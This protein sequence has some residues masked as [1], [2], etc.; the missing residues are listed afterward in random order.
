MRDRILLF[1]FL[2][3][4]ISILPTAK[5]QASAPNNEFVITFKKGKLTIEP[6]LNLRRPIEIKLSL[7]IDFYKNYN[8]T[9]K[10]VYD[11]LSVSFV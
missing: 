6:D 7:Q 11:Y 2:Q 10:T 3:D 5:G 8:E 4:F 1:F 9:P